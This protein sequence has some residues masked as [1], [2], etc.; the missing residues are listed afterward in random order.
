MSNFFQELYCR[1]KQQNE[2]VQ[3][4]ESGNQEEI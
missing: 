4:R 3:L 2:A 1:G